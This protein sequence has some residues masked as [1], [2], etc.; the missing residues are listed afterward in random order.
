MWLNERGLSFL[1]SASFGLDNSHRS[2]G[3]GSF[4]KLL[5]EQTEGERENQIVWRKKARRPSWAPGHP[6]QACVPDL[7]FQLILY[8]LMHRIAWESVVNEDSND[9]NKK[10]EGF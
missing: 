2:N 1:S 10:Y 6:R 7:T 8:K 4:K 5:W 9:D 3:V